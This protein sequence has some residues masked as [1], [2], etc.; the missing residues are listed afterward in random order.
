MLLL[1]VPSKITRYLYILRIFFQNECIINVETKIV[2]LLN[3]QCLLAGT[4][5]V[6]NKEV[7]T[8]SGMAW[9]ESYKGKEQVGSDTGGVS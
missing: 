4:S 8:L 9:H 1:H 2:C 3:R 7:D 6:R 5:P